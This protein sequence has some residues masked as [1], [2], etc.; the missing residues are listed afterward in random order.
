MNVTGVREARALELADY[1]GRNRQVKHVL[2]RGRIG[3]L[4]KGSGPPGDSI[5]FDPSLPH[6]WVAG[7]EK[8]AQAVIVATI[9]ERLQGDLM[10]RI[11]AAA[12]SS[13]FKVSGLEALADNAKI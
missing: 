8:A 3:S 2:F 12:G 5:H 4:G 10:E 1:N 13:S 11:T 7:G 6:R 9:P